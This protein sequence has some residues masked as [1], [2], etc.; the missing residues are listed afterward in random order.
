MTRIYDANNH[1]LI[2]TGYGHPMGHCHMAAHIIIPIH[3]KLKVIS[4]E[5]E[6]LCYGI[7]LP[8]GSPHMIDTY[9]NDALVFLYDCTTYVAKQIQNISLISEENCKR[10]VDLYFDF[11]NKCSKDEYS[12]FEKSVL[13]QLKIRNSVSYISDERIASAVNY[14]CSGLSKQITCKE[15]ADRVYLSQ[16]RFSHLF[17]EQVGM[18]FAAYLIYRRIMFAYG[19]MFK[20]KTITEAAL[21]AG[22]CGSSHFAD[23]NRRVFGLSVSSITRDIEFIKI[24]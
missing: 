4:N 18:T 1:I 3:G 6:Y 16:G 15:V 21:S 2:H 11:Q 19:E 22:F 7:M 24:K 12:E 9:K 10:I 5:T 20:G 8:S 23:V 14:I 17:K 13:K